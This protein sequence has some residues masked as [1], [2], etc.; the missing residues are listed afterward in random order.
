MKLFKLRIYKG[1]YDM[2]VSTDTADQPI[3][4]IT[5]FNNIDGQAEIYNNGLNVVDILCTVQMPIN[6]TDNAVTVLPSDITLVNAD[7]VSTKI[8][9]MDLIVE[10]N[11]E[12]A[13][14]DASFTRTPPDAQDNWYYS[15][16]PGRFLGGNSSGLGAHH[17]VWYYTDDSNN[18]LTH[19]I[20]Y[21]VYC[22]GNC[23]GFMKVGATLDL[24]RIGYSPVTITGHIGNDKNCT[25]IPIIIKANESKNLQASDFACAIDY[26]NYA[27]DTGYPTPGS[28]QN[29]IGSCYYLYNRADDDITQFVY[30][31]YTAKNQNAD[32][33]DRYYTLST[34]SNIDGG[35]LAVCAVVVQDI[36]LEN[37]Q[38]CR[39]KVP[40][41]RYGNKL[42]F[43]YSQDYASLISYKQIFDPNYTKQNFQVWDKYGNTATISWTYTKSYNFFIDGIQIPSESYSYSNC[44]DKP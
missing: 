34:S 32:H 11:E 22:I 12:T 23:N 16:V 39:L 31:S 1:E 15:L 6:A 36:S 13:L 10:L 27:R 20:H 5:I 14:F 18:R 21:F 43:V 3:F 25:I 38:P 29:D 9:R 26:N 28:S 8:P 37:I 17:M 42:C 41:N 7:L 24:S 30:A 19:Y 44:V 4:N 40:V 2:T 33:W 35:H